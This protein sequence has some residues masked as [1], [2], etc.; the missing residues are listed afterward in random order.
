MPAIWSSSERPIS[1]R[2][3]WVDGVRHAILSP[4]DPLVQS[5]AS[6]RT[7]Q[8]SRP[9]TSRS[10]NYR[11]QDYFPEVNDL[12]ECL[13]KL[14]V[15]VDRNDLPSAPCSGSNLLLPKD[16]D[17]GATSGTPNPKSPRVS[18]G[19]ENR[20]KRSDSVCTVLG[21][22]EGGSRLPE[23]QDNSLSERVL[24][25]LDLSGRGGDYRKDETR[26]SSPEVAT[27]RRG[28]SA[29]IP[30]ERIIVQ[31]Y[32]LR[33]NVEE[34]GERNKGGTPI[35]VTRDNCR[36]EICASPGPEVP[37]VRSYF[38]D[39]LTNSSGK[40]IEESMP[41]EGEARNKQSLWSPPRKPQLHI[42]MP[43]LSP[44]EK[45]LSSIESLYEQ[46]RPGQES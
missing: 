24:Q 21:D 26:K 15:V 39:R 43:T 44:S 30:K 35:P 41:V 14:R 12:R 33:T 36:R 6:L 28:S 10:V 40:N 45:I 7:C 19:V 46:R 4:D 13:V 42:F 27:R 38:V 16:E 32:T 37:V 20:K 22:P 8:R 23:I 29:V 9:T 31:N 17:R 1:V 5:H 34:V 11:D 3:V 2:T 18:R 25:W